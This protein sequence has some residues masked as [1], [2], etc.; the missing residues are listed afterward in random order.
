[1]KEINQ[2]ISDLENNIGKLIGQLDQSKKEIGFLKEESIRL[3]QE[4]EKL[5]KQLSD[6]KVLSSVRNIAEGVGVRIDS[7]SARKKLNELIREIDKCILLLE[8]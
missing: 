6:S 5:T 2:L 4:N 8:D 1:M 7:E 3:Q